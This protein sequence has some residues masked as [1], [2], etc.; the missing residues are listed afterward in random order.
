MPG[1]T[2]LAFGVFS[3]EKLLGAITFGV[4][5]ANVY[6]MIAEASP[7]DCLTLSRLWLSDKL[8]ANSESRVLGIVLRALKRFTQIKFIVS[9]ADPAKGHLGII[10]QATGWVYT[11]LSEAMPKFDLGDGR[12]RHSRSLSHSHGSHSVKFFKE[13]GVSVNVLPQ[14]RKHRYFYFLDKA[15][16]QKLNVSLKPYPKKEV[17]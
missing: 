2:K 1:G 16:Q 5:P 7:R 15:C 17:K 8:P 13:C 14:S 9:Y 4:G 11:G 6:K 3:K 12:P 10:Y